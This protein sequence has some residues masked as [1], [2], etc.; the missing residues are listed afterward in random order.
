MRIEHVSLYVKD[1]EGMKDFYIRYFN[2]SAG[3]LYHNKNTGLKTYFLSFESG[4]RLELMNKPN[5]KP[6]CPNGSLGYTHLAFSAGSKEAVN[7]LT[8]K[9]K[10]DGFTVISGPRTT[11]D[12]YYE[13]LIADPE[14]NFIEITQ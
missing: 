4:A 2:A 6:N 10:A 8:L 9:L 5:L 11:G 12:G 3:S 7:E 1:L 14:N 13:S